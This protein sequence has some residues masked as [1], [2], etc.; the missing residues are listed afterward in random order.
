MQFLVFFL[1]LL[2]R[3]PLFFKQFYHCNLG[4]L[5]NGRTGR[6][7]AVL[8]GS[9]ALSACGPSPSN[10]PNSSLHQPSI[11]DNPLIQPSAVAVASANSAST[12]A[13]LNIL[14][15]GGNAFDAAV[16]VAASLGVV[17]PYSAGLGGGGF[18][19]LYEAKTDRYSFIDARE[20]APAAADA[21]YYLD[22]N[23]DVDRQRAINGPTAA[24]IPGQPAALVHIAEEYGRLPLSTSLSEA[25]LQANDG[26]AVT[27]VYQRWMGYRKDIIQSFA[28]SA[29][30]FLD[31][32]EIPELGY[33]IR[34]PQLAETLKALADRGMEGFYEG[35]VAKSMVRAVQAAGGDW[36]EDDLANYELKYRQP[37]RVSVGSK[38]LISAP[39]P[40]SGGIALAQMLKMLSLIQQTSSADIT[41][42]ASDVHNLVEVMRRAYRD[43][44][45]YLGDPDF[46]PVPTE[47]LL[48][49]DY[50]ASLVAS[51]NAKQATPSLEL[52]GPKNL[53]EGFH[54][55]HLSVID[56]EGNRVSATLSINLPFGS[57]FVA[58]DTGV[59]LNNEMDDFSA[60]PGEPNAYGLVGNDANAIAPGKRP[61]SSMTPS[62]MVGD[63]S[64]AI[65]G[66]PG[67]SRIITMVLLGLLQHQAGQP[68]LNW[69]SQPRFHHQYLPDQ[70]Q[71]EPGA[72]S[73][74]MQ[75]QLQQ[76]GHDLKPLT[77]TYGNMQAIH[78]DT[79]LNQVTAAS[80][81]RG[82]GSAR[83]VPIRAAGSLMVDGE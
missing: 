80:D 39:P 10:L 58:G 77:R 41:T 62:M 34:Q 16:A 25:I 33:R 29:E 64:V 68:V 31:D 61:L 15:Q 48:S 57:G 70:I 12:I 4:H 13:G 63:D 18:W 50:L 36:T 7:L 74:D 1:S 52:A 8:F 66:T 83:V 73:V 2:A 19:L 79:A 51:I 56:Q 71:F 20:T 23:G 37:I 75:Q 67:G 44:A 40:S 55:T 14:A 35:P 9:V 49:D 26:F 59:L 81:P 54:T 6:Y 53:N 60:K 46:V 24:G 65:I 45:E 22:D 28:T 5:V 21:D 82:E 72:F 43:R 38:E 42:S 76:M 3:R 27:E 32:Q 30:L 47:K 11:I 69:V 17:E 78:W